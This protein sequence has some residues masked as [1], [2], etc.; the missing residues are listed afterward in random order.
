MAKTSS[1]FEQL[2]GAPEP[3]RAPVLAVGV[4]LDHGVVEPAGVVTAGHDTFDVLQV[5]SRFLDRLRIVSDR[6][7]F[8]GRVV[9]DGIDR[10]VKETSF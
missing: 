6:G 9:T 3:E 7:V 1:G 5:P 8:E 10:Y 4:Q 2:L